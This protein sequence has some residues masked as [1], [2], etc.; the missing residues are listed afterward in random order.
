MKKQFLLLAVCIWTISSYTFAQQSLPVSGGYYKIKNT[1]SNTYIGGNTTGPGSVIHEDAAV[2]S[3][4]QVFLASGDNTTGWTFKQDNTGLYITYENT[5]G[6]DTWTL[7]YESATNNFKQLFQID[8]T[9]STSSNLILKKL[10]STTFA[11]VGFGYDNAASGST[12]YCDK[13]VDKSNTWVFES[14]DMTAEWNVKLTSLL[15]SSDSLAAVHTS[16]AGYTAFNDTLVIYE[17]L[18]FSTVEDFQFGINGLLAAQTTFKLILSFEN[19]LSEAENLVSTVGGDGKDALSLAASN[20]RTFLTSLHSDAEITSVINN[21]EFDILKFKMLHATSANPVE[22]TKY[23]VNSDFNSDPITTGWTTV[24]SWGAKSK[25]N[26][27]MT[28]P[29]LETYRTPTSTPITRSA[30]QTLR[31]MPNGRYTFKAVAW[32]ADQ[33]TSP[34]ENTGVVKLVLNEK[35]FPVFIYDYQNSSVNSEDSVFAHGAVYSVKDVT[36][37][38]STL[39]FGIRDSLSHA[40]WLGMDNAKLYYSGIDGM[41][42]SD[43]KALLLQK[44]NSA[45]TLKTKKMQVAVS[46]QL[47]SSFTNANTIYSSSSSTSNDI[48]SAASSLTTLI[49]TA[50]SSIED[51]ISLQVVLDS[52]NVRKSQY[53]S[54]T[55]YENLLSVIISTQSIYDDA[56]ADKAAVSTAISSLLQAEL[57]CLYTLPLPIDLTSLILANPNF[58]NNNSS[59]WTKDTNPAVNYHVCEYYEPSSA[60]NFNQVLKNLKPGKYTLQSQGFE[61]PNGTAGLADY[62]THTDSISTRLYA[63]TIAN[64]YTQ[65]FPSIFSIA[66]PDTIPNITSQLSDGKYYTDGL[67]SAEIMFAST[68]DDG[69]GNQIPNFQIKLQSIHVGVND[70]LII[71]VKGKY[72]ANK[73][74]EWRVFDNFHLIYEGDDSNAV[75]TVNRNNSDIKIISVNN[76]VMIYSDSPRQI[77]IYSVVGV[78]VKTLQINGET[79]VNLLAGIYLIDKQKAI[80]R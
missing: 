29:N 24:G 19:L 45:D 55:G 72:I 35:A 22:I 18:S 27:I 31:H 43:M 36:V 53:V 30:I 50:L 54:A 1:N 23:I 63:K 57:T 61:R 16:S 73:S 75:P 58:N 38:D 11:S 46:T 48:I 8:S 33:N 25:T 44:I 65:A 79:Y 70:S 32:G 52:V 7:G 51:Y 68:H 21:L 59:G 47:N 20:G 76:G 6:W 9:Q 15:I 62:L 28:A 3:D 13:G 39:T 5:G 78:K 56:P 14:V 67:Q 41:N 80:V 71:G 26:D 37:I 2:N 69:L 4:S 12:M 17:N 74:G 49:S 66:A 77:S 42:L 60:F 10:N 64:E 40:N 34:N